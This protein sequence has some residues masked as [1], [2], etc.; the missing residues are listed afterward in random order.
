MC[1]ELSKNFTKGRLKNGKKKISHTQMLETQTLFTFRKFHTGVST[2]ARLSQ[3]LT[4]DFPNTKQS[5]Q[6]P[7][8]INRNEIPVVTE[9]LADTTPSAVENTQDEGIQ[10]HKFVICFYGYE[11]RSLTL[12]QNKT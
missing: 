12:I 3:I 4:P 2:R 6:L 11:I 8:L 10:N 9:S 7:G 5:C 1:A